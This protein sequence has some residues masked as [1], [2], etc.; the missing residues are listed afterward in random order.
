MSLYEDNPWR[1]RKWLQAIW[2]GCGNVR[3][4]S[5]RLCLVVLLAGQAAGVQD[6]IGVDFDTCKTGSSFSW[7][8]PGLRQWGLGRET[9]AAALHLALQGLGAQEAASEAFFDNGT[10]NRVF[11]VMGYRPNGTAWATQRGEPALLNRWRLERDAGEAGRRN[12]IGLIGVEECK[13]VLYIA[14]VSLPPFKAW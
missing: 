7:L 5:R 1:E 10:S 13:P 12:D 6:P 3:P 8:A 9:R 4:D 14:G 2:P 11:E